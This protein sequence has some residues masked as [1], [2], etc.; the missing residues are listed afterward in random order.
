MKKALSTVLP[1][2]SFAAMIFT[3]FMIFYMVAGTLYAVVT[4]EVF[5][6]TIPFAFV[7]Q[8]VLLSILI[9]ALWALLFNE[10]MDK[11][12]RWFP[13]LAIFAL[14]LTGL[15]AICILI[16]TAIPMDWA[17]LWL[18][19]AGGICSGIIVLSA[20]GELYLKAKGKRYT[21]IL[22]EYQASRVQ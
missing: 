17:K 21:D 9:S 14:A 11:K 6:Y 15:L 2:K 12:M 5:D 10:R 1:L 8:G 3:G 18:F 20:L 19:V 13:R 16:F 4:G 7:L 22:R